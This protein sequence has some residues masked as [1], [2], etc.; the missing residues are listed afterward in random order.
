MLEIDSTFFPGREYD[1]TESHIHIRQ[2]SHPAILTTLHLTNDAARTL[3]YNYSTR[4][5]STAS[6][7]NVYETRKKRRMVN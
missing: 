3:R 5:R 2:Y 4:A 7:R 1:F 6:Y